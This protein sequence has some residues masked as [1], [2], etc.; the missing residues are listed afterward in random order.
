MQVNVATEDHFDGH[1]GNDLFDH[2]KAAYRQFKIK[3][4]SSLAEFM[5][6]LSENLVSFLFD[7]TSP[8]IT[9]VLC[10]ERKGCF[11][12]DVLLKVRQVQI[13]SYM[14]YSFALSITRG[15]GLAGNRTHDLGGG[16]H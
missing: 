9:V 12:D 13:C 15:V 8:K 11:K 5:G 6:I 2:E 16:W 3:K 4:T 1:Q 14:Y 10:V 7:W